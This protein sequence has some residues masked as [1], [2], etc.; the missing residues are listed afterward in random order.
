MGDIV[1]PNLTE[2]CIL[3][4]RTYRKDGW[5][6]KELGQLAGE[7]QAMGPECV[8]IT[9]VNQGGYIMNVVAEGER[10]AFPRTRRVGVWTALCVWLPHL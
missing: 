8:V 10:T 1:T 3:T 2:A 5:S 4:G 7:I 6:R 9:G